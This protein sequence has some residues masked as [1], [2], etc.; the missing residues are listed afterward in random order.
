MQ[1][2]ARDDVEILNELAGLTADITGVPEGAD[3]KRLR[4]L[5]VSALRL[6]HQEKVG[7]PKPERSITRLLPLEYDDDVREFL[8]DHVRD[9]ESSIDERVEVLDVHRRDSHELLLDGR[10]VDNLSALS[11]GERLG[12]FIVEGGAEVW[13]D[14][15][16]ATQR[17]VVIESGASAPALVLTQA[18]PPVASD[19]S[20]SIEIE[21]GTVWLRGD[22]IDGNLPA[23]AY[24][25]VKVSGGRLKLE[26]TTT[27]SDDMVK[28]G[29][30]L[31]GDL[32]LE[33]ALDEVTPAEGGCALSRAKVELPDLLRFRFG[34]GFAQ[35]KGTS[36]KARA[37]DQEFEFPQSGNAWSFVEPLWTLF[38]EYEVEPHKLDAGQ[39]RSKLIEYDGEATIS[40]AGLGLPVVVPSTAAMLGET[41]TA[42]SW[43]LALE[44]FTAR[45]YE[46]DPRFHVIEDALVGI[47]ARGTVLYAV[48][49]PPL[50]PPVGHTYKLWSIAGSE[51]Q[52]LPWHQSYE[53]QFMLIH[54]CDIRLGEHLLV[55]GQSDIAL[56][57]PVQIAG[58]PVATP[59][60]HGTLLLHQLGKE[61][62]AMLAAVISQ[63]GEVQQLA[64]RNA[65]TWT[66]RPV[67][68]VVYG[69]L[70]L[71]GT[72]E[73]GAA[74][75]MFGVHAWAPILPDPYVTNFH[76]H[77][78]DI[79]KGS[80]A[81][82][83]L[84]ARI[85]WNTPTAVSLSFQGQFG[86]PAISGREVST[87]EPKP[88]PSSQVDPNVGLTQA[89]QSQLHHD[90]ET[91]A[92][93]ERSQGKEAEDRGARVKIAQDQND[94]MGQIIDGYL[95]KALGPEPGILLLDVSTNQDLL[96]V[97]FSGRSS[98]QT[99]SVATVM[100]S[101]GAFPVS[102]LEVYSQV[103]N[104]RVVT[105]PQV[106]WEPVRTLDADQD[107]LTLGWF[108]TPLASATDGGPTQLGAHSQRLVPHT[109]EDALRGTYDAYSDGTPVAFRT[110][111]PFGLIAVVQLQPNDIGTR[112]A[113]KY[114]LTQP[115]FPTEDSVG[116]L[117]ITAQA[118]GAR[119]DLGGVSPE[120]EGYMFQLINGVDLAS[121]T[122]LGLSV[123][124][125]TGDPDS[126]VETIFN[127]DMM[128]NPRVPVSRFDLSGYGGSNFSDWNNPFAAFAQA[129]K[130]QFKVMVGRAALEI[131]KVNSVLHPWGIRVTRS[132]T[133]E[134]RPGGGVIR[135][136]SGWQPFTP[137]L[138]D[139]RYRDELTNNLIVAPYTFDAGIFKGLFDVRSIRPAPGNTFS[140]GGDTMIPYYFDAELALE[141]LSER[142]RAIGVLGYLQTKP[143]GVPVSANSLSSLLQTQGPIGGPIDVWLDFGG[144]GLPFR[145]RRVE[146]G[147]AFDGSNP[148]FVATVRGVPK[149]PKTG[150]WSVVTR[151]VASVPTGGGE[152]VPVP[153][154]R[155]VPFIRRYPIYYDP[156]NT[157]VYA[158]PPIA[159]SSVVG[160]YRFADAADLLVPSAPA[161]DYALLQST[162]THAF[163]LPRPYVS[164]SG[165]ARIRSDAKG[166]VADLFARSTS[167]GAF[168]PPQNSIELAAG[169]LHFDIGSGGTL[170]L[171]SPI[172]IVNHPTPL[173]IA[174]SKG[175]GTE[176]LYDDA[177]LSLEIKAD[178]WTAEF[179][180]LRIWTDISGMEQLTGSEL[181]IVGS[182]DQRS[183]IAELESL[184]LE[185]IEK[186]LSY[187]PIFGSRGVQGPIDLGASNAKHEIKVE[188]KVSVTIPP[189][190]ISFAAGADLKLKLSIKQSTGFDLET[191]GIKAS[192]TFGAALDGK[193]P[194]LSV[195]AVAVFL[196]VTV[197]IDL[198]IASLSG[199]V[200]SEKL[201]LLAFVG[202]G[203]EG[204]IG[205]FHAYAFLGIGFVLV[206][207]IV[208]DTAK[209]GGIVVLEAG[210][211]L[212]IVKVKIRAELKGLV[213]ESAGSTKCDYSGSVKLQVDIFLIFSISAT[214][215][216]TET[217]TI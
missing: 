47:S 146:V 162:P 71:P 84:V 206:Y 39:I 5:T 60:T 94:E 79:K 149:L 16:F 213:Y 85:L 115:N 186:I 14:I 46:P 168:P 194:L 215:Q 150:A 23:A 212:T 183:Q 105:L 129:A 24:V 59:T 160:D 2:L 180:G 44:N 209:Y 191:G 182:T 77:R 164:S 159:P 19:S 51:R 111:L 34:L 157:N 100:Q 33:P 125:S 133:V 48:N 75:L 128:A 138:F 90:E 148:I 161:N 27:F 142:T 32:R 42:P 193:I 165:S 92:K 31:R 175:H 153:E 50:I 184:V 78:P 97:A 119:P 147:L 67:I 61:I 134:R 40:T 214:Y 99:A 10:L 122:P 41:T 207:E 64:L 107:I 200:T 177:T 118:E 112:L 20:T 53:Q 158:E 216:V 80:P 66:T 30:T 217:A 83:L 131:I 196:V 117:H 152:A 109:P 12:P 130:V 54:R 171:S 174:G 155:G 57:R 89:N 166:A 43:W 22:L 96:G 102:Q 144:S 187:I 49:I 120:F 58:T 73:S 185:D 202:V 132:I 192:A 121:G 70:D 195:A 62:T 98:R 145:A 151:P 189:V 126:D 136:D 1:E 101:P 36:G 17:L 198:S 113:D 7:A 86:L 63:D 37:W 211:D 82:T 210:V 178:S 28:V 179:T 169:S 69:K 124:G 143:N 123:L 52:R 45:W 68:L 156:S 74:Q 205:P 35:V 21:A 65:L 95:A 116:G 72:I 137:G 127:D 176:L 114:Q 8:H 88:A 81:R 26:G 203:V 18:H 197:K 11:P 6:Q 204:R 181:R 139:Y 141:G 190:S 76:I 108:P 208:T 87:G 173:R 104:M 3:V 56:D 9:A 15:F 91:T 29:S 154:S 199:A 93:W 163:L 140:S 201:E 135:R 55:N 13:F 106:Q 110:T 103:A 25:G 170:A 167:K 172:S 188:A 4:F 38:L